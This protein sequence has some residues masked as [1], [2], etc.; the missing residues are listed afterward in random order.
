MFEFGLI[1]AALLLSKCF[2]AYKN[3]IEDK[4]KCSLL[5][6]IHQQQEKVHDGNKIEALFNNSIVFFYWPLKHSDQ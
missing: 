2:T 1:L 3:S 5:M 4:K 6:V